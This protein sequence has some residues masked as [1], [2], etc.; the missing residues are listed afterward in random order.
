MNNI[1]YAEQKLSQRFYLHYSAYNTVYNTALSTKE[2]PKI[3]FKFMYK[4]QCTDC[5][6]YFEVWVYC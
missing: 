3:L 1:F 4:V 2:A 6:S 5:S